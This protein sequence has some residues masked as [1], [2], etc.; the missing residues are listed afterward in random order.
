MGRWFFADLIHEE[1]RAGI[2]VIAR[3]ITERATIFHS[4]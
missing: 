2:M 4:I 3:V 1:K